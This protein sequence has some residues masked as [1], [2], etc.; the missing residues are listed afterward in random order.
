MWLLTWLMQISW[1][2]KTK[3]DR[4]GRW[5]VRQADRQLQEAQHQIADL[6]ERLKRARYEAKA[7]R[8]EAKIGANARLALKSQLAAERAR[9]NQL[10]AQVKELF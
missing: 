4:V 1:N 8:E 9:A 7:L 2:T 5:Q 6:S 10:E 3:H